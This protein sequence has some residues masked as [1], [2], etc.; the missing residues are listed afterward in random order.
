MFWTAVRWVGG[1]E[2]C[3]E[4]TC[5]GLAESHGVPYAFSGN[6][7]VQRNNYE[8]CF[9]FGGYFDDLACEQNHWVVCQG[10]ACMP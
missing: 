9:I 4:A 2:S 7:R 6:N 10:V 3:N 8:D 1:A 5:D